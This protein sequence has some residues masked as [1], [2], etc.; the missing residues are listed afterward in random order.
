MEQLARREGEPER[1]TASRERKNADADRGGHRY[2][3]H[4]LEDSELALQ[5]V[6]DHDDGGAYG[7]QES[8]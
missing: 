7:D 8:A 5:R 4:D 2:P 6:D 1:S 3:E